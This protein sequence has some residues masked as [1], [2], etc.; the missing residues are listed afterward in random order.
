MST[1][2]LSLILDEYFDLHE[3]IDELE[4]RRERLRQF[5]WRE[6]EAMGLRRLAHPRG[7]IRLQEYR[8]IQPRRVSD[9]LPVLEREGWIDLVLRAQ[10]PTLHKAAIE[11]DVRRELLAVAEE[12]RKDV[13]LIAPKRGS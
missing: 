5:A 8:A 10:G 9:V 13:L 4:R 2:A 3:A 7:S 11:P 6:L 12:V 1:G